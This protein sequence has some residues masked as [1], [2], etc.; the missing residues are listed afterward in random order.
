MFSLYKIRKYTFKN[1]LLY[2]PNLALQ[3]HVLFL[4]TQHLS[5]LKP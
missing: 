4:S 1:H 2:I 3:R 5:H